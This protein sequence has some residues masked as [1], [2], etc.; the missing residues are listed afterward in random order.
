[1]FC[2]FKT[3]LNDHSKTTV[4]IIQKLHV[5]IFILHLHRALN[6]VT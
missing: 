3:T 5:L 2:K 1:V 6:K 4:S